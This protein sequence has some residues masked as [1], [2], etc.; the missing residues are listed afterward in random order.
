MKKALENFWYHYKGITIVAVFIAIVLIIG[1]KSCADKT[2]PDLKILYFSDAYISQE[3]SQI[4]E[5]SLRKEGFV[6]DIDADGED[7]FYLDIVLDDFNVDTATDEAT[8]NKIMAVMNAGDHTVVLAHEY[9]LTDYPGYFADLSEFV[10]D[11]HKTFIDEETKYVSGISVKG[12]TFLEECGID[13][14]NLYVA[15]RRRTES[16]IKKGETDKAFEL[17]DEVIDYI[18]SC[19]EVTE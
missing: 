18:L 14:E 17:A 7:S 15:L 6:K 4:M 12:N 1:F 16:E 2:I 9:A 11:E 19:N 10:T 3:N 8:M 13:T 5:K